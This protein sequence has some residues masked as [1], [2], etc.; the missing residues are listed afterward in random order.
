[1]RE[2]EES[3]ALDEAARGVRND[4]DLV[5]QCNVGAKTTGAP[6]VRPGRTWSGNGES[7]GADVEASLLAALRRIDGVV[8]DLAGTA[9]VSGRVPVVRTDRDGGDR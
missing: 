9:D 2:R 1:M 8:V 6:R 7:T 4:I 3:G 5:R